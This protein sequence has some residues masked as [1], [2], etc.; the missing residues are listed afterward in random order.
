M[1]RRTP[2]QQSKHDRGVEA[3]AKYYESQGY[4]VLADIHGYEQ[5]KTLEGRRPDVIATGNGEKVIVEVETRDS[6]DTDKSQRETFKEYADSH[7]N[8]RF[9]TKTV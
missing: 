7:K 2:Q 1:A 5:P 4:T 9:W 6:L 3:L 8:I